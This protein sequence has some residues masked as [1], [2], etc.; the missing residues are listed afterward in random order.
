MDAASSGDAQMRICPNCD[1]PIV[2]PAGAAPVE[3]RAEIARFAENA[4]R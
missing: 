3:G 4:E 2:L 1:E